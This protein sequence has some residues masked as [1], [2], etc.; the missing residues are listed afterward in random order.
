VGTLFVVGDTRK[1]M[2]SS[3]AT[4]FDPVRGDSIE[5][6]NMRFASAE[7]QFP[8]GEQAIFLGL[9]REDLFSIA[10]MVLLAVVVVLVILLVVRPLLARLF[11][12]Q[13]VRAEETA[14]QLLAEQGIPALTGPGAGLGQDLALEAQDAADELEQMIDINRVEGRVRASSVRKVGEIVDK[15]PEEAVAIIRNW[16]YQEL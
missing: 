2:Q 8:A 4:G 7:D 13:A 3:H 11:E 10:E 5:V 12:V 9:T 15:H 6:V 1:V 14:D 16:M